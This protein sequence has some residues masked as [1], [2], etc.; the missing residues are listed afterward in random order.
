MAIPVIIPRAT[1]TMDE[2][3]VSAWRKQPGERVEAGEILFEMETDKVTVEVPAPA[4]GILLRIDVPNGIA[5]LA[6]T[7]A[8]IGEPEEIIP[9][10]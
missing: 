9:E 8:W 1:I 5:R 10:A 7:I 6:Q 3:S 4:S 2:A